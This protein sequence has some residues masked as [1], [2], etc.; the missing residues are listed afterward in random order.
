MV[1]KIGLKGIRLVHALHIVIVVVNSLRNEELVKGQAF[2]Y[3][4]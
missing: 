4:V 2:K 1:G 3:G